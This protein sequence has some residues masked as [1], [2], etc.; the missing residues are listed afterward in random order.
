ME[1]ICRDKVLDMSIHE[2]IRNAALVEKCLYWI[3]RD[4]LDGSLS[5]ERAQ[6][7]LQ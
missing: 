1:G 2:L 6:T 4:C 3:L 7:Q 5:F